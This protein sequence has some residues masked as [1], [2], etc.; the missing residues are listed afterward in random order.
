M[1]VASQHDYAILPGSLLPICVVSPNVV[2][3]VK[4]KIFTGLRDKRSTNCILDS[5][6]RTHLVWYAGG[7]N[8]LRDFAGQPATPA[9]AAACLIL[10]GM[11]SSKNQDQPM[12]ASVAQRT[13]SHFPSPCG[14]KGLHGLP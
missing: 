7:L 13:I 5:I 1:R 10:Q 4:P 2:S 14:G 6:S 11:N 9:F 12:W 3:F 8:I